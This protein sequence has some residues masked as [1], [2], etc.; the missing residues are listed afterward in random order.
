MIILNSLFDIS[1]WRTP[2]TRRQKTWLFCS[3]LRLCLALLCTWTV[4]GCALPPKIEAHGFY[5]D[6]LNESKDV[7]ILEYK[8]GD[9]WIKGPTRGS[10][11]NVRTNIVG[12]IP[13]GDY[14][15]VKWKI[16][17]NGEVLEK[18]VDLRAIL[19]ENMERQIVRFVVKEKIL[20]IFLE[21]LGNLRPADSPIV[22]PF[23]FQFYVT[24]QIYPPISK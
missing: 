12:Y 24:R 19:P 4:V 10:E 3:S 18:K 22:G 9:S 8:Y 21:H 23:T 5:Y 6:A 2:A 16:K 14:L 15:Y 11:T 13:V 7:E 1:E 17:A 20:Y